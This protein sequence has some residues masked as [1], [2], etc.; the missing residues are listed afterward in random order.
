MKL[1]I[2][3]VAGSVLLVAVSGC[4]KDK[5]PAPAA[6]R[7]DTLTAGA[8]PL[9]KS[10][11]ASSTKAA[12]APSRATPT[13]ESSAAAELTSAPTVRTVQVAALPSGTAAWWANELQR[14]GIPAYTTSATVNGE[15][16]TRLRIGAAVTAD[17]ARAVADKIHAR[18]QWP[19]WIVTVDDRTQL[20]ANALLATRRYIS[21]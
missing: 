11:A 15:A 9:G 21:Q 19:T 1:G 16:V 5:T 10:P 3:G 18:Y 7:P 2:V 17:E 13:P 8:V 12:A 14:Q 4:G 6:A 20:P